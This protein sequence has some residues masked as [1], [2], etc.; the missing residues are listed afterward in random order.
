M[1]PIVVIVGHNYR[2]QFALLK[3]MAM[4]TLSISEIMKAAALAWP[5]RSVPTFF[6][7]RGKIPFKPISQLVNQLMIEP[8]R[9]LP[10]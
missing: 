4:D 8:M 9:M 6:K 3:K 1:D 2:R 10:Q 5:K 7:M